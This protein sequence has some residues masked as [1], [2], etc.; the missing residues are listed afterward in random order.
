VVGCFV[1]G[2][3]ETNTRT[4]KKSDVRN[5]VVTFV[6]FGTYENVYGVLILTG[7]DT[8]IV[9]NL[10]VVFDSLV[11]SFK[12]NPTTNPRLE[13][14]FRVLGRVKRPETTK[15]VHQMTI[16]PCTTKTRFSV[17]K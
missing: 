15:K 12:G 4:D 1:C 8:Y 7:K 16:R 9:D 14:V 3:E 10:Q 11:M 5:S 6:G 17:K 2:L 13:I